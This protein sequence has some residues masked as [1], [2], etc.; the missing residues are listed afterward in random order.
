MNVAALTERHC[1]E[2]AEECSP[3]RKPWE[4]TGMAPSPEGA[5]DN[6]VRD[7]HAYRSI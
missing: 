5:R 1:P 3:R 7:G 4:I 2:G 6:T